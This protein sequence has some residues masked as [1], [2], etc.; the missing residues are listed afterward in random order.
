L[1]YPAFVRTTSPSELPR[2]SGRVA[3][4]TASVAMEVCVS[5]RGGDQPSRYAPAARGRLSGNLRQPRSAPAP[6]VTGQRPVSRTVAPAYLNRWLEV[7]LARR[8][9][10]APQAPRGQRLD[11]GLGG[12][13][14]GD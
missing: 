9:G 8:R 6:P 10:A 4:V 12:A 3:P 2:Q 11:L 14:A 5:T 1:R 13:P 7:R